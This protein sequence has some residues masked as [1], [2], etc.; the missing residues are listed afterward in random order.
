MDAAPSTSGG[1]AQGLVVGHDRSSDI[2]S[3]AGDVHRGCGDGGR[4]GGAAD[5]GQR[6]CDTADE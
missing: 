5:P 1:D 4:A 6:E 3:G 2:H